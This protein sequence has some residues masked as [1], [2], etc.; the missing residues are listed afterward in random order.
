MT[1]RRPPYLDGQPEVTL[2]PLELRVQQLERHLRIACEVIQALL[3]DEG[4]QRCPA[5]GWRLKEERTPSR[6][7]D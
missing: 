5:C 3:D 1:E 6:P 7:L 2:T 4:L